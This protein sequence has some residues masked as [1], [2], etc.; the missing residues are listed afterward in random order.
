MKK[1]KPKRTKKAAR[2]GER[3]ISNRYRFIRAYNRSKELVILQKLINSKITHR[4]RAVYETLI[5]NI[6][7][8]FVLIVPM[9]KL[10]DEL[11]VGY[12]R[13]RTSPT[14]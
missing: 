4:E 1:R 6:R 5:N 3:R 2:L 11:P 9:H 7:R 13:F 14:S 10:L 12:T 8:K